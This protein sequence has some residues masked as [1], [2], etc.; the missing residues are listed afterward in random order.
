MSAPGGAFGSRL[1]MKKPP[2]TAI[3]PAGHVA[4]AE[5]AGLTTCGGTST[6]CVT[7]CVVFST[8]APDGP[9]GP[10]GPAGPRAPVA[11]A[12]PCGPAGPSGPV[13]PAGPCGP[14]APV[15]A[16]PPFPPAGPA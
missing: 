5:T 2:E 16:W 10:C 14:V 15:S 8:L 1:A 3:I 12:G 11:P 13:A 9:P 7:I 6:G 4:V